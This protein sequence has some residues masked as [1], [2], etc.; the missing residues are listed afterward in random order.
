M[1]TLTV[2]E[3]I[4]EDWSRFARERDAYAATLPDK[5]SKKYL[6]AGWSPMNF[7]GLYVWRAV[8][9]VLYVG[10]SANV[11]ERLYSHL[12]DERG[13]RSQQ[14]SQVGQ[15]VKANEPQSHGWSID[16]YPISDL[17]EGRSPIAGAPYV[18]RLSEY[19][20]ITI[21]ALQPALNESLNH[22]RMPLPAHIRADGKGAMDAANAAF[23][24]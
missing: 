12:G 6:L 23:G 18:D 7:A 3:L 11:G 19:E 10:I 5:P 21:D 13:H 22:K 20:A 16:V 2:R 8:D 24:G 1:I 14:I 9:V 4:T 17:R 15:L